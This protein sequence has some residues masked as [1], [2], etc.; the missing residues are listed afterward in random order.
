MLATA[1]YDQTVKIF[2]VKFGLKEGEAGGGVQV[3]MDA[4]NTVEF[5]G[6][7]LD[8]CWVLVSKGVAGG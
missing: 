6:H 5:R 3:E 4:L 1:S 7:V 8:A 2:S